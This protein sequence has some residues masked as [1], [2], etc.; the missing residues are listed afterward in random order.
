MTDRLFIIADFNA[1]AFARYLANTALPDVDIRT[2]PF[3]QVH[4][5]LTGP[6]PG[7]EW[8]ALVWTRP[9]GVIDAFR[10]AAEFEPVDPALA[11]EAVDRFAGTVARFANE[12]RYVFVPTWT[13]PSWSRG[14]GMLDFQ[15]GTGLSYLL[16]RMNQ[17]LAD[18]LSAER[19]VFVL[20]ASRWMAAVGPRA[21]SAKLWYA[22]KSPF[23]QAVF[24]QAAADLAAALAGLA[25]RSRRLV[26]LDLDNILWGGEVGEVGWP[27]VTLGGHDHVGEAFVDFQRALKALT[28]RGVQLAIASRNDE[29]VALDMLDRHPEMQLRREDFAA[30]RINWSDKARSVVE[31]LTELNLGAESAVFIDDSAVERARIADALPGVLTPDW[32]EDPARFVETLL[33]LPCFDTP[34]VTAE[35]RARR[36]MY[37][38]ERTRR[39]ALTAAG[40]L[41]SWLQSLDIV[42]TVEPLGPANLLRAGQLLNK[43]NQMN[44]TTRRASPEELEEWAAQSDN[45][46][47]TFRVADRFGDSGLTGL[48]GLSF[49]NDTAQMTDF[50]LSCRVLG[51]RVE[52]TLLSAAVAQCRARGASRLVLDFVETARNGP[53]HEFL[54]RS[55]L[56]QTGANRFVWDLAQPY[57]TPQPV[58]LV[59]HAGILSGVSR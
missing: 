23:A 55:G 58:T 8:S 11:M 17:T 20:D 15:P 26:I 42:V 5:S 10:R 16:S 34:S 1:E 53:C 14:Y 13:R 52:E 21:T 48:V 6:A 2:A 18:A 50:L 39:Q 22:S 36:A 29:S 19:N 25:G 46:L 37:A 56:Q 51:R 38:D 49:S 7:A 33:G 47:L 59:D 41:D 44:L 45:L 9:D 27:A 30:W 54:R 40:D 32:P 31:L 57:A 35:D 28:R 3:G 43:T 24:E 4:Q 12:C